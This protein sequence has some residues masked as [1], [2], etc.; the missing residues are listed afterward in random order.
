MLL[1]S[2]QQPTTSNVLL[3]HNDFT[4]SR[5]SLAWITH[6]PTQLTSVMSAVISLCVGYAVLSDCLATS[7]HSWLRLLV[8]NTL[9]FFL[10]LDIQ[11]YE[12]V[13]G[14]MSQWADEWVNTVN[15]SLNVELRGKCRTIPL[16][17]SVTTTRWSWPISLELKAYF[18]FIQIQLLRHAHLLIFTLRLIIHV[19]TDR[20]WQIHLPNMFSS[21]YGFFWLLIWCWCSLFPKCNH[22]SRLMHGTKHDLFLCK[23]TWG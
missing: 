5:W 7:L 20:L 12:W 3:S 14:R 9:C 22:M 1:T 2:T 23:L 10:L 17:H 13:S 19:I 15:P 11:S 16:D 6:S 8:W 4:N 18:E 21:Q